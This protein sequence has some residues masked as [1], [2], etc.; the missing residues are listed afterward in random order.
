MRG[1]HSVLFR[2]GTSYTVGVKNCSDHAHQTDFWYLLGVL[3]K[4][5]DDHPHH[6]YMGVLPG[7][8]VASQRGLR[9]KGWEHRVKAKI[10]AISKR[11]N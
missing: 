9:N 2:V 4:I 3:F 6:F 5:S 1:S 10:L 8:H 11:E 7:I